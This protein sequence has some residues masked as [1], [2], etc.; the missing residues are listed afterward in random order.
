MKQIQA[1]VLHRRPYRES[2]QLIDLYSLEQG[3]CRVLHRISKKQPSLEPFTAYQLSLTGR[4]QLPFTRSV[5]SLAHNISLSGKKLYCGFYLNELM[6]RLTWE[7]EV[8]STLFELYQSSLRALEN[9]AQDEPVLRRFEFNL[10]ALLGYH[11]DWRHDDQD[12]SIQPDRQYQ[13]DAQSGFVRAHSSANYVLPGRILL[14]I[15]ED[16]WQSPESWRVAKYV[17]RLALEPLLGDKPLQ[18]RQLF[19]QFKD[20]QS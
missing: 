14:A 13:F 18:S 3:R 7:G 8:N 2:S 20:F 12:Q 6:V 16:D 15:A 10:L 11:Y 9:S 19:Q 4:G 5:E 1:F 17:A